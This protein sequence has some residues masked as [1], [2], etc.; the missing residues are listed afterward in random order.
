MERPIMNVGTKSVIFGIHQF[1]LHPFLVT[2]SWAMFYGK[3]PTFKEALCIFFHDF[4]YIGKPNMDGEE[5]EYHPELGGNIIHFILDVEYSKLTLYH[6]R[7]YAKK[8]NMPI[9]KLCI[10]VT[11]RD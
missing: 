4:G 11:A 3:L 7:S 2:I 1:F 10:P 6:S 8:M 5:G 9:S